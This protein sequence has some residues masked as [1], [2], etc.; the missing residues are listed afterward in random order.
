MISFIPIKWVLK[1]N[2]ITMDYRSTLFKFR[3]TKFKLTKAYARIGFLNKCVRYKVIPKFLSFKVPNNNTF[4][5]KHVFDFQYNLISSE[6][7]KARE[8]VERL[9][10][11]LR[12]LYADMV[13]RLGKNIMETFYV[14]I[15]VEARQESNLIRIKHN[16][17]IH[18]FKISNVIILT[19]QK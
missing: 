3:R 13:S 1:L 12:N 7:L 9:Q 10:F 6:L 4:D 2:K 17:K 8:N 19:A 16:N 11:I 18:N 14:S 5:R 15:C